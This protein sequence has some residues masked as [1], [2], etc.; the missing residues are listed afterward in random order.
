[1]Y[2]APLHYIFT[3]LR[4]VGFYRAPEFVARRGFGGHFGYHIG[5]RRGAG[6]HALVWTK[7]GGVIK[8]RIEQRRI[9]T[10]AAEVSLF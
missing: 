7:R 6:C 4:V 3:S 2:V 9:G 10:N 5:L 1:M 8:D